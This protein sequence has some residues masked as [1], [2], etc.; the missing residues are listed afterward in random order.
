MLEIGESDFGE[1]RTNMVSVASVDMLPN[2]FHT[3]NFGE[4]LIVFRVNKII[5]NGSGKDIRNGA[6][7]NTRDIHIR[8][9]SASETKINEADNFIVVV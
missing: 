3:I 9:T 6:R 7:K 1:V 2:K 5:K 8:V 4:F